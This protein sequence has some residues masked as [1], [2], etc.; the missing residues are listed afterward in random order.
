[1]IRLKLILHT[2]FR[3]KMRIDKL[4]QFL[5]TRGKKRKKNCANLKIFFIM[6][7]EYIIY[8]KQFE[9]L[10][11]RICKAGVI[12][13][14]RHF[15]RT[16]QVEIPLKDRQEID[17]YV[18]DLTLRSIEHVFTP[19]REIKSIEGIEI[20]PVFKFTADL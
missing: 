18:R 16:H 1:M 7:N 9:V 8:N 6:L 2:N 12:G 13:V 3:R 10:I 5:F 4:S 11:C 14:H 15:A 17:E 19:T 20:V